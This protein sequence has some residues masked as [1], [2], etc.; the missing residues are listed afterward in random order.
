MKEKKH[1]K[2]SS[3]TELNGPLGLPKKSACSAHKKI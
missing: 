2:Q 1:T 3:S